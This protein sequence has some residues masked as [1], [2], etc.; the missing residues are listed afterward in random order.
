MFHIFPPLSNSC[1]S[2]VSETTGFYYFSRQF[3]LE[4]RHTI[5]SRMTSSSSI[6]RLCDVISTSSPH[7]LIKVWRKW[8][9]SKFY[10]RHS[11]LYP[12]TIYIVP[13]AE[14]HIRHQYYYHI[15]D[16]N[17]LFVTN[18][19]DN[20]YLSKHLRKNDYGGWLMIW[21]ALVRTC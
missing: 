2:P 7:A 11:L 12:A 18:C 13:I 6:Y 9:Y 8:N 14:D 10:P 15:M 4:W 3:K 20:N 21:L 17:V 5:G 19:Q 1:V 16:P